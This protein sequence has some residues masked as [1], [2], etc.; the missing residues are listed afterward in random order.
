MK[1][2]IIGTKKLKKKTNFF[3]S[4][5]CDEFLSRIQYQMSMFIACLKPL[6]YENCKLYI[7]LQI[8]LY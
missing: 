8:S 3:I 2:D 4:K 5:A 1:L 6:K 7:V